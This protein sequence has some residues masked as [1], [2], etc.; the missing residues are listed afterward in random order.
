MNQYLTTTTLLSLSPHSYATS[1]N[2]QDATSDDMLRML[3]TTLATALTQRRE[4]KVAPVSLTPNSFPM[5]DRAS[6]AY[7]Q[8]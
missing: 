6:A 3:C 7:H 5:S 4:E 1:L 2:I 8:I